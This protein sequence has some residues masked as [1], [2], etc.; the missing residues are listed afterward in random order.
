M[1]EETFLEYFLE[2][3]NFGKILK[4]CFLGTMYIVVDNAGREES[5]SDKARVHEDPVT[6][7]MLQS[8]FTQPNVSTCRTNISFES[9]SVGP[10]PS[11]LYVMMSPL[12]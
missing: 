9:S 3:Q 1:T 11:I 7:I 5:W 2:I 12:S 6:S 10:L 4:K 8:V